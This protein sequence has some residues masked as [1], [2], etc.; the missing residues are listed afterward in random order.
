MVDFVKPKLLGTRREF[1]NRFVNPIVNGQ[2][3]DSSA[4]DVRVMKRRAHILHETLAGCVQVPGRVAFLNPNLCHH[5][6]PAQPHLMCCFCGLTIAQRLLGLDQVSDAKA[7][8][9]AVHTP[10]QDAD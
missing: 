9:C 7:R 3:T 10:L 8:I 4:H 5:L 1:L 2:C 6:F